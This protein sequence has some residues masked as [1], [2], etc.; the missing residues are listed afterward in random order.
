MQAGDIYL[1]EIPA[2]GGHEQSGLR[3]A[4]I[5]QEMAL[6]KLPTVLIVPPTSKQ[7]AAD[8]PFTFIIEPDQMNNLNA[9]SVA[10]IFQLRAIDKKRVKNKIGKIGLEKM[11]L[12]KQSLREI[13]EL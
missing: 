13:M 9:V 10:L 6:E 2:S 5:V 4:I 1:I 8:F 3:P 7:K 11:E 12:L